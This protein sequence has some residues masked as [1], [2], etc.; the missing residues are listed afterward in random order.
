MKTFL[1][2]LVVIAIIVYV[3][4]LISL[5]CFDDED[6]DIDWMDNYAVVA[7]P[8]PPDHRTD[9]VVAS[10]VTCETIHT[11]CDDCSAVLNTRTDC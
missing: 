4:G 1:L 8:H 9:V 2:I 6:P 3:F 7:C 5:F 10:S 11:I